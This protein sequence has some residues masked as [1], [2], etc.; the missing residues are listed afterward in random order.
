MSRLLQTCF[1]ISLLY[2]NISYPQEDGQPVTKPLTFSTQQLDQMLAPI[3]LYP[4]A[5]LAHILIAATYPLEVVQAAR[6]AE[7]KSDLRGD[8]AIKAANDQNWDPSVKALVAFPSLLQRMSKDL[9]WLQS[10][11]DASLESEEQITTSI[12]GLRQR[13]Y[14]EGNLD[15]VEHLQVIHENN[16]IV[17]EPRTKEIIYIPYYDS[18]YIY[19]AWHWAGYPPRHWQH[20]IHR[21]N[22]QY[23][24]SFYWGPSIHLNWGFFFSGFQWQNHHIRVIDRSRY[25][26]HHYYSH[27]QVTHHTDSRRW[28]HNPHHRRGVSYRNSH[29]QKRFHPRPSTANKH[30]RSFRSKHFFSNKHRNER[31][32]RTDF[33]NHRKNVHKK[34]RTSKF[35]DKRQLAKYGK[36]QR[37][38]AMNARKLKAA[39]HPNIRRKQGSKSDWQQN[40][41]SRLEHNINKKRP[42][43]AERKRP[44]P[45]KK[46]KQIASVS[47]PDQNRQWKS[48]RANNRPV[49]NTQ[50]RLRK[51]LSKKVPFK[52][53]P[54]GY[55]RKNHDMS[56]NKSHKIDRNV[57]PRNTHRVNSLQKQSIKPS[58]SSDSRRHQR[59]TSQQRKKAQNRNKAQNQR[60][61][62][63]RFR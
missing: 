47:T 35:D 46:N 12:Q 25:K 7:K 15:S 60:E 38:T 59:S 18:R 51:N 45:T 56:L 62:R 10:L 42:L 13:A 44:H 49:E 4:D 39:D 17:I 6:W 29:V 31:S 41:E 50:Q 16:T 2:S 23:S 48:G 37:K 8:A 27:R 3:A 61:N 22:H 11:G 20:P 26:P 19:G 54:T 5:V 63:S 52:E 9:V 28:R 14:D 24:T 32:D 1:F 57:A 43:Y 34:Y 53:K 58:D 36:E 21:S 40:Q 33:S 30:T 55:Q